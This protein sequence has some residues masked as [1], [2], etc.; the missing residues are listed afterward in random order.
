MTT[1]DHSKSY[2]GE[3]ILPKKKIFQN[4]YRS[5]TLGAKQAFPIINLINTPHLINL[6]KALLYD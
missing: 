4:Y 5:K 1:L 6:I 2:R 3:I